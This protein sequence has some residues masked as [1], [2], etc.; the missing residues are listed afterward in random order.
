MKNK[1]Y[2]TYA[3][4]L[5]GIVLLVL[6]CEFKSYLGDDIFFLS[7]F[8]GLVSYV[9]TVSPFFL[10]FIP[11]GTRFHAWVGSLGLRIWGTTFYFIVTCAIIVFCNI[12]TPHI[13]FVF[14]FSLHLIALAVMLLSMHF[15]DVTHSQVEE[16]GILEQQLTSSIDTLKSNINE[17]AYE[18]SIKDKLSPEIKGR[19]KELEEEA[20][21]ISPIG[22]YEALQIERNIEN[23]ISIL[24]S[25]I[26]NDGIS[27][28]QIKKTIKE[29]EMLM[30]RRK[31]VRI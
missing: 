29:A 26:S 19:I 8:F 6:L 5:G 27:D 3:A 18:A 10:S 11:E 4:L 7:L 28:E 17:L 21:Y 2:L 22:N 9:I 24:I 1:P 13:K 12:Y 15:T 31:Q 16:V 20:R 14:Q 30:N 25:D 23:K